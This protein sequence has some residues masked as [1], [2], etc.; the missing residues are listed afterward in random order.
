[1][2]PTDST[3]RAAELLAASRRT[4]ALTGAETVCRFLPRVFYQALNRR[5]RERWQKM[6]QANG[7]VPA[8]TPRIDRAWLDY[9]AHDHVYDTAPLQE[10]G[11][12]FSYPDLDRGLAQT[13]AWYREKRWL[14]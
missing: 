3:V 2:T 8:L 5:V 12:H 1:M 6:V 11:F 13:L 4:V 10:I 7:L 9:L 14:P